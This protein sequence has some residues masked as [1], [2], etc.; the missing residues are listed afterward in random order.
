MGI[1][2]VTTNFAIGTTNTCEIVLLPTQLV[3]AIASPFLQNSLFC[4]PHTIIQHVMCRPH[5]CPGSLCS[6]PSRRRPLLLRTYT[7]PTR[8]RD[9]QPRSKTNAPCV[10]HGPPSSSSNT[11]TLASSSNTAMR[12]RYQDLCNTTHLDPIEICAAPIEIHVHIVE[13]LC[14]CVFVLL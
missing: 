5:L 8:S 9:P 14:Y 7:P 13:S 12:T 11:H 10:H 1:A 4:N 2:I 3:V 6:V